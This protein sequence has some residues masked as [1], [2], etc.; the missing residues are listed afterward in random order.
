MQQRSRNNIRQAYQTSNNGG[1]E[2]DKMKKLRLG[3]REFL[4]ASALG[5][6][7]LAMPF[8]WVPRRARAATGRIGFAMDT[9]TVPRWKN[10]DKPSFEAAVKAGGYEPVVVQ[11][12]FD[13]N[14]QMN[15]VDNLLSQGVD[16][17]AIVP[18]VSDAAIAMARK[19]AAEG[20]PVVAYNTALPSKDVSVFVSRDNR[21][22]GLKAVE[23]AK[24]SV[25]LEGNWVI[26][27]GES[28][29]AVAEEITKGYLEI[30]KPLEAEGKLKIVSH[31]FH[32]GWDPEL[33]RKQAEN[34]LTATNN[35]IKGF[36]CNN[37]GMA[38]GAIAALEQ[39][40]LA[41]KVFVTGQDATAEG[42]RQ[43]AEGK[44]SLSSF[45]RFDVMGKTAGELCVQLAK[46][47]KIAAPATY[48]AGGVEIPLQP[49]EDFNVTKE[50]LVAY[51]EQY[52]PG[53]VDAKAVFAGMPKELLPPGA[54][55]FL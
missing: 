23:A 11:A 48:M 41:G 30:L 31:E 22:V 3:R 37:D 43:I 42:C 6:G 12:N 40:K 18:V 21:S 10:L 25:G 34:A 50:N 14:Q 53:Y 9:Y 28:G 36:L 27:S 54:E 26:V 39:Q 51:L 32:K 5:A 45:T 46:G 15:D 1:K 29:N 7:A 8:I 55:K 16:A 2:T 17:L 24:A 19:A 13:V 49:I 33:A 52:S 47:E 20:V 35:D 44:L 4:S 38:G